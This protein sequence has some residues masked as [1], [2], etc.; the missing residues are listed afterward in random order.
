MPDHRASPRQRALFDGEG[1]VTLFDVNDV[2]LKL[3]RPAG[4]FPNPVVAFGGDLRQP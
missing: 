3:Y 2:L 1:M 4:P